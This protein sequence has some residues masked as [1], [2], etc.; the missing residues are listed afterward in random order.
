LKVLFISKYIPYN[1]NSGITAKMYNLLVSLSGVCDVACAYIVNEDTDNRLTMEKCRLNVANY[2]IE[3][4][5]SGFSPLRYFSHMFELFFIPKKV[6]KA[7]SAIIEQ[8]KPDVMWLEFGYLCHFVPFARKFGLPVVYGSHNSQFKLD[9]EIW[10]SNPS[11]SY[12]LKMAPFVICYY[13]HERLLFGLPDLFLCISRQDLAYYRRF[14]RSGKLRLL[15]FLFDDSGLGSIAPLSAGHP[16]ICMVGSLRAYQNYSAAMFALARVWPILLRGNDTLH[17]YLVGEL[18]AEGSPDYRR[19][20]ESAGRSERV[21]LIGQ[22]D[23][24]IPFVKGAVASLIPLSI[25]SGVRTKIIESAACGTP[26]VSTT[27]GAEGLP[28]VDGESILIADTANGLAEKVLD[29]VGDQRMRETMTEKAYAKYREELSCRAGMRI[30]GK[31][32]ADLG[33]PVGADNSEAQPGR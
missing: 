20:A 10:R 27:V 6:K 14:I 11:L 7:L 22:V 25:G 31:I 19:L 9:F 26:M 8:E 12:R 5:K 23:S 13:I 16:Y 17:L 3:T 18:P 33:L 15:P 21:V 24:V 32:F 29:L 2:L 1:A 4:K 28:F 30:I